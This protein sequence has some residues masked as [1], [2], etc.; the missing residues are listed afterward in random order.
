MDEVLPQLGLFLLLIGIGLPVFTWLV[1]R[2]PLTTGALGLV[3]A[4]LEVLRLLG[5][6]GQPVR[7]SGG[8]DLT[9]PPHATPRADPRLDGSNGLRGPEIR[10]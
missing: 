9:P 10:L 7:P 5:E 3:G 8:D 4:V 1:L 6:P 2:F